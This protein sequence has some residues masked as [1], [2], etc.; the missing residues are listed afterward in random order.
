MQKT[1]TLRAVGMNTLYDI[2]REARGTKR[3]L[4]AL[5]STCPPLVFVPGWIINYAEQQQQHFLCAAV[6]SSSSREL[7]DC[8]ASKNS[9]D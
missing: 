6:S 4:S 3:T 5:E 9:F 1:T 2:G 8:P 7:I